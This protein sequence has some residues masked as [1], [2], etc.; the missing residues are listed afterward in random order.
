VPA[1]P[2]EQLLISLTLYSLLAT[3]GVA[4]YGV[5]ARPHLT[6]KVISV[7]IFSDALN[8]LAILLGFK[9]RSLPP[10]LEPGQT[11][12]EAAAVSVDPLPQALVLTAIVIG[13]AVTLYLVYLCLQVYRLHG[14]LDMRRVRRLRE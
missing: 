13:L 1:S 6:K 9:P 7:T 3:A 2:A 5:A 11:L 4:L 14:T 10:G 12:A 8:V